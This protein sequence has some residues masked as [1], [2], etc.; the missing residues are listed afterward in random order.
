MRLAENTTVAE[1][2]ASSLAAVR[3]F[4]KYGIDYCCG[5]KRPLAEV[6]EEKGYDAAVIAH[7]LNSAL[8]GAPSM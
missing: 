1:M 3:I 5:G 6:C 8:E 4:E 2:A 7:E